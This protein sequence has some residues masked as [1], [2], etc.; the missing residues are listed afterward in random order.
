MDFNWGKGKLA[1]DLGVFKL[2]SLIERFTL[3]PFGDQR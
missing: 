2:H 1:C 3:H